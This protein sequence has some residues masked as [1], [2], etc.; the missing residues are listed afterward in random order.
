MAKPDYR[1]EEAQRYRP[2]YKTKRWQDI[3]SAQLASQPLCERCKARGY[4]VVATV[5][6]H[7]DKDSK[8]TD[9]Y[10]GPFQSVCQPC[11]DGDIQSE[12]R[13]GFSKAI[14]PDGWPTDDR[15]PANARR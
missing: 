8:A 15:H 12:E 2:F 7:V 13:L 4:I 11:H 3:R 14:G 1:S 6:H 5:C 9:F 10:R